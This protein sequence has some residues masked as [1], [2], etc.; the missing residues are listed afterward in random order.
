MRP[1]PGTNKPTLLKPGA[2]KIAKL[3]G[4]ADSY[5]IMDRQ[6]AAARADAE[7]ETHQLLSPN[8]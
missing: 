8:R 3:L 6:E 2:E 1:I 7:H 4:L 5:E